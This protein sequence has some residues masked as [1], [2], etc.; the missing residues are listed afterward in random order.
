M[1]STFSAPLRVEV[2]HQI[3][4]LW[5][6]FQNIEGATELKGR[7]DEVGFIYNAYSLR[8]L[9]TLAVEHKKDVEESLGYLK[10]L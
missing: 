6:Q 2:G 1:L 10:D 9:A 3:T 8:D 5:F 4:S 7:L